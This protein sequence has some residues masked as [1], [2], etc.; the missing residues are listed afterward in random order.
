MSADCI[1]CQRVC[2]CVCVH[3]SSLKHYLE[4]YIFGLP[5]GM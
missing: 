2:V 3:V 4:N 5:I 1:Q